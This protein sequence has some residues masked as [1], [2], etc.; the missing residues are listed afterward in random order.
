MQRIPTSKGI[1]KADWKWGIKTN[2]MLAGQF[3]KDFKNEC[4]GSQILVR[5]NR[6]NVTV[7]WLVAAVVPRDALHKREKRSRRGPRRTRQPLERCVWCW[8]LCRCTGEKWSCCCTRPKYNQDFHTLS[9]AG[10]RWC[11]AGDLGWQSPIDDHRFDSSTGSRRRPKCFWRQRQG[12]KMG[13]RRFED[14]QDNERKWRHTFSA[15]FSG[16]GLQP[17]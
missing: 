10:M 14:S 9:C 2:K 12:L 13:C 4:S 17:T 8:G 15:N 16:L 1:R 11:R 5:Q 7:S 3:G 6:K